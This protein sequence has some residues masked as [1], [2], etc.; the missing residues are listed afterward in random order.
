M[1]RAYISIPIKRE[2]QSR[3]IQTALERM[4]IIINNPCDIDGIHGDSTQ[5]PQRVVNECIGMM[6]R[7]DIG[8][9]LLDYFGHDCSW[10]LGYMTAKKMPIYGVYVDLEHTSSESLRNLRQYQQ[11]I[12][13]VFNSVDELVEFLRP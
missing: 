6:D 10:E 3:I 7:S 5:I 12:A 1:T 4:G 2:S 9:L 8:I 13:K 11:S